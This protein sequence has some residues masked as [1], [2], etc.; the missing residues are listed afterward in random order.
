M[1]VCSLCAEGG[2]R[3]MWA[4]L[5]GLKLLDGKT[6]LCNAWEKGRVEYIWAM[7]ERA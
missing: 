1:L 6:W 2:E 3:G 7:L 4:M 5:Q